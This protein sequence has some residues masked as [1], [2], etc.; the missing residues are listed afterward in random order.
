[1]GRVPQ[2]LAKG[3]HIQ[4]PL[5]KYWAQ[6]FHYNYGILSHFMKK[7]ACYARSIALYKISVPEII[8]IWACNVKTAQNCIYLITP[9][10]RPLLRYYI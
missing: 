5:P 6:Y 2:V 9:K 4:M 7:V 10:F 1:M 3:T 8:E